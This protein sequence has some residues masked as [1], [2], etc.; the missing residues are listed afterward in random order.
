MSAEVMKLLRKTP[1]FSTLDS[2]SLKRIWEFFKERIYSSD[3]VLFKEGTLGDTLYIIK[4]G[5]IKITRSAKEGEEESSRALRREGDIFGESGFIDESPRPATAQA[6]KTTKVYQLSRSDFLTILNNHPLVAYQIVKVLSSRIKQ[7]DLRSIEELKER[8]EQLQQAFLALQERSKVKESGEWPEESAVSKDD[9]QN[10]AAQILNIIPYPLI[11]TA[12][13]GLISFF[14]NAAEKEFGF[15]SQEAMGKPIEMLWSDT[16][17]SGLYQDIV[18]K[19]AKKDCW[20]GE[21]IAKKKDDKHFLSFTTIR[22]IKDKDEKVESRLYLVQNVTQRKSREKEER[23]KEESALRQQV[24]EDIGNSISKE[25]KK[26]SDVFATLPAEL[27]GA[28]SGKWQNKINVMKN[29]LDNIEAMI[30]ELDA[31]H[32]MEFS[33]EP[34]DLESFFS[35]ELLLLESQKRFKNISFVTQFEEGT[36]KVNANRR[37]LRQMLFVILDN[38]VSALQPVSDR[39]RT[40]TIEVGRTGQKDEVQI[41]ISD[42]GMGISASDLSKI[43][44]ERFTAKAEG[45]GLGLLSVAKIVESLGGDIEVY[46]DE[47]TYTLFVIK[48]PACKEVMTPQSQREPA[49]KS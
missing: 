44:K 47:G 26:L 5:A 17:W 45:L 49:L 12:K 46:S 35:E 34:L 30:S 20:E 21:I 25:V 13:D 33:L 41:Q 14:N 39:A 29:A 1:I 28:D 18:D 3:E 15:T 23:M 6:I 38:A 7:S 22:E 19:L 40:I 43:F 9:R 27:S 37:Q 42:N 36:P 4:E 11:C 48:F 10:F 24:A 31:S 8:N 2:N 32:S 16:S